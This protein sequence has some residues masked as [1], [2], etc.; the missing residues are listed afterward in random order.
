MAFR[1]LSGPWSS[2]VVRA[3]CITVLLSCIS[4]ST[5]ILFTLTQPSD[6][7]YFFDLYQSSGYTDAAGNLYC[8]PLSSNLDNADGNGCLNRSGFFVNY[9]L[10]CDLNGL[11]LYLERESLTRRAQLYLVTSLA[12]FEVCHFM[13][14]VLFV[15][16]M[17][18]D[19]LK[20]VIV[21][22][23]SRTLHAPLMT[24]VN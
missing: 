16:Y 17:I 10:N 2:P 12:D 21:L 1:K 8:A 15:R 7:N 3:R 6:C 4:S 18:H 24:H 23:T 11:P 22:L 9:L 13:N 20:P 5:H 19:Y 14:V